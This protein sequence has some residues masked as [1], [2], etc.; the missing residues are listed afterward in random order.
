[1]DE[2]QDMQADWVDA[3]VEELKDVGQ[4]YILDDPDQCLYRTRWHRFAQCRHRQKPR[5]L[6]SPRRI[7]ELIDLLRLTSRTRCHAVIPGEVRHSVLGQAFVAS[8]NGDDCG[9][10]ELQAERVCSD[11]HR[12]PHL[13]EQAQRTARGHA[14]VMGLAAFDG[15][16]QTIQADLSG[17]MVI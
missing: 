4:L 6:R 17:P 10:Q 9:C 8:E 2:M 1:M 14:R 5:K 3:L 12:D 16:L 7:V 11:R 15:L 13:A